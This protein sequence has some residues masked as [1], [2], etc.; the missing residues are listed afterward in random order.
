MEFYTKL[1]DGI[2]TGQVSKLKLPTYD[3]NHSVGDVVEFY[4]ITPTNRSYGHR[5]TG[6]MVRVLIIGR[7]GDIITIEKYREPLLEKERRK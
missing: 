4:E 5:R 3:K 7:D 6:R 2:N 1:F